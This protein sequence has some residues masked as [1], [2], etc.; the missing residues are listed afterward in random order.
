[1]AGNVQMA[2]VY[3]LESRACNAL[4]VWRLGF[5]C[6]AT[7]ADTTSSD[8]QEHFLDL[9]NCMPTAERTNLMIIC[10]LQKLKHQLKGI[11]LFSMNSTVVT[12]L[13]SATA[14]EG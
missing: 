6:A 10:R 2:R 1:M 13:D 9:V 3:P 5:S 7:H 14:T 4:H 8:W 11:S 12:F